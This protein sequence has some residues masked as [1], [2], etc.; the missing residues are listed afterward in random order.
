M[1]EPRFLLIRMGSLGDIVHTLPALSSLR[2]TFPAS[3]IDW[4]AERKWL[5]LLHGNPDLTG[6]VPIETRNLASVGAA[7]GSLR[8]AGY[9]HAIDFQALY[10]SALLALAS[11]ARRRIGFDRRYARE[12]AAAFLYHSTV[13]PAG[14]HKVEHN[15][16][17]VEFAGARWGAVRF[18]LPR[19]AEAESRMSRRLDADRLGDFFVLCPGGGWRS[20]CWPAE[21]RAGPPEILVLSPCLWIS[22]N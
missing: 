20:K 2:E 16:S 14:A 4:L 13:M 22:T 9:S 10:K 17:L 12:P 21:R 18:P 15:L 11:G 5:P 6:V 19:D 3:R 8:R 1:A 7:I